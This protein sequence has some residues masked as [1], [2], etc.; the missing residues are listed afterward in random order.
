MQDSRR[1][2]SWKTAQIVP[3]VPGE[4][5]V[6]TSLIKLNTNENPYDPAPE[7]IDAVSTADPD[8]FRLYPDPENRRLRQVLSDYYGVAP[9]CIFVGNG[10]DEVLAMAFQA[11]FTC[12]RPSNAPDHL[13]ET[14]YFPDITY[15]FYPVYAALYD[16]P[17]QTFALDDDL[18]L[19]PADVPDGGTGLVLA[20]PNA[21]T[22]RALPLRDIRALLKAN[23]DRLVLVD[24]AYIDFGGESAIALL[25][26]HDNL[27]IV[28]TMSKSRALAGLRVG[29]A[30]GPPDLI[31][32]L[33]RIRDS[34]NSYTVD[35]IAQKA[36]IAA[37]Q[38]AGWFE[39]TRAAVIATREWFSAEL[40][41]LGFTVIPS[42]ANFVLTSHPEYDAAWLQDRL[43][44]QKILVRRFNLPRIA[45]YLRISIG[46]QEDM[47][48]VRDVL[49]D[50]CGNR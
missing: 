48:R 41:Q 10:S 22:G 19:N 32:G 33:R 23:P 14:L 8:D 31:E 11:F 25:P 12:R 35:R 21:P 42:S 36:A 43:R 9:D 47:E 44:Q 7:V 24:E 13:T 5:P 46:R 4:Q 30:I 49:R 17:Y 16:I 18:A 45:D 3:Y 28:Q 38:A 39:R 50:L 26:D 37:V 27:L 34:F 29:C 20:N 15:S 40:D 1:F 6:D 2:W